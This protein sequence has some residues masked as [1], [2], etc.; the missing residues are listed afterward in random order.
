MGHNSTTFTVFPTMLAKFVNWC[1]ITNRTFDWP[2]A[3]VSDEV[4]EDS[5]LLRLLVIDLRN[6]RQEIL[7]LQS[8]VIFR[9]WKIFHK[10]LSRR[11]AI[12]LIFCLDD[13]LYF[14]WRRSW[15]CGCLFN[16][17]YWWSKHLGHFCQ[18]VE[19]TLC[20]K[21]LRVYVFLLS[22]W[23]LDFFLELC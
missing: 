7:I 18:I 5:R 20:L 2:I 4:V 3:W 21:K 22:E 10:V 8:Q 16:W 9:I 13:I 6:V 23:L 17:V 1:V 12:Y 14:Q 11:N 19:R 15:M